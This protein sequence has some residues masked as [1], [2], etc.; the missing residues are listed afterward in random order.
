[1]SVA[2]VAVL[3]A[4]P[5]RWNILLVERG[6]GRWA[7]PVGMVR[8]R[9]TVV[10]DVAEQ[11]GLEL[12]GADLRQVPC[13]AG[14]VHAGLLPELIPVGG[15]VRAARWWPLAQAQDLAPD[16][17]A[18]LRVVAD[19]VP[20]S[21]TEAARLRQP[22]LADATAIVELH[23]RTVDSAGPRDDDL[24]DVARYYLDA[25]GDFVVGSLG[26]FVLAMGGLRRTVDGAAE[27]RRMGV[28]PRWRRRG[29]GRRVLEHLEHRASALG[30]TRL[31]LDTRADQA[32]AI[33][34]YRR[35]GF[36]VTGEALVA[37]VPS[38]L[39]EKRL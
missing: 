24:T 32:A 35:S 2:E 13:R 39:F 25:G 4:G 11:T 38:V 12:T 14:V 18:V 9:G 20:K 23:Q 3:A 10:R 16:H 21:V 34:L 29:L 33:S 5:D 27:V 30:L 19:L 37:G 17:A 36:T 22:V 15:G 7:L 31:V 8:G 1:M 26:G 6:A 28:H